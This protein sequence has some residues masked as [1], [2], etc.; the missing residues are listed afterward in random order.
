MLNAKTTIKFK[1]LL[2]N[3]RN[4]RTYLGIFYLKLNYA[5]LNVFD[6]LTKKKT[7]IATFFV[8]L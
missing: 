4:V 3:F 2:S 6:T 7:Q 8:I 1:L 5:I